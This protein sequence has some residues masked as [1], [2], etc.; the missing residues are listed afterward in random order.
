MTLSRIQ[1]LESLGFEWDSRGAAW[2]NR[3]IEV[4]A[5]REI[6]GHCNVPRNRK[7]TPSWV[8]GSVTKRGIITCT[9]TERH[10]LSPA[11]ESSNWKAWVS[12][13]GSAPPPGKTV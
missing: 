4:A 7:K 8:S 6:H 9:E 5:Y 13:G 3:L 12:T 2:E 10:H 11:S 1:Q